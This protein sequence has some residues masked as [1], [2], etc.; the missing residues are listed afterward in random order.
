MQSTIYTKKRLITEESGTSENVI[1]ST[2]WSSYIYMVSFCT[3]LPLNYKRKPNPN[4]TTNISTWG[5]NWMSSVRCSMMCSP[6]LSLFEPSGL[7]IF[8]WSLYF[9][10]YLSVFC[11]TF[12][13]ILALRKTVT[14]TLPPPRTITTLNLR[15]EKLCQR[16]VEVWDVYIPNKLN[17]FK[18]CFGYGRFNIMTVSNQLLTDL[19]LTWIGTY[20]FK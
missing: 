3:P 19:N 16:F 2:I 4:G 13:L 5:L 10:L 12:P 1:S 18:R 14:W 8:S 15:R 20:K 11:I 17:R 7:C 9:K 6:F